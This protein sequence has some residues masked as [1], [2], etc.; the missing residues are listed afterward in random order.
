M[1]PPEIQYS[2][3]VGRYRFTSGKRKG[4]FVSFN[5]VKTVF[6]TRIGQ[7]QEQAHT[8]ADQLFNRKIDLAAFTRRI[9]NLYKR[10]GEDG[11]ILGKPDDNTGS[12]DRRRIGNF[13]RRQNRKFR[14]FVTEIDNGELSEA[15]IRHRLNLFFNKSNELYE[16][17]VRQQRFSVGYR[18][19]RRRLTVAEHCNPCILYAAR[20]W[21]PINSLPRVTEQCDCMANDKCYFEF[22]RAA[23]PPT[24][25][26]SIQTI[27]GYSFSDVVYSTLKEVIKL[28]D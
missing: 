14:D 28:I 26:Q 8:I 15:M 19:E 5:E 2:R 1:S 11:Y 20:G 25:R 16:E 12:N 18:W 6:Q 23:Q 10:A 17:G 22:S 3:N 24:N 4:R 27:E 13:M 9:S 21:V 7:Y